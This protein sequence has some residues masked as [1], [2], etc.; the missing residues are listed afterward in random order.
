MPSLKILSRKIGVRPFIRHREQKS[1]ENVWTYWLLVFVISFN[2]PKLLSVSFHQYDS[3]SH[4]HWKHKVAKPFSYFS[5]KQTTPKWN[6]ANRKHAQLF[7]SVQTFLAV[8]EHRIPTL[9][10][11]HSFEIRNRKIRTVNNGHEKCVHRALILCMKRV[12]W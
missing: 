7:L 8:I 4:M 10:L 2:I 12:V 3:H 9:Q 6:E 5:S 11:E 1:G